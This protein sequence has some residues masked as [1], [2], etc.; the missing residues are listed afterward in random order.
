MPLAEDDLATFALRGGLQ[1]LPEHLPRFFIGE[2][3]MWRDGI[4]RV[5]GVDSQILR[6]RRVDRYGHDLEEKYSTASSEVERV[7]PDDWANFKKRD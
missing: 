3:V 5:T 7:R 4:F 2:H 6:L 1:V